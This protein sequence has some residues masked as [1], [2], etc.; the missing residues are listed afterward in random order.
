MIVASMVANMR[1]LHAVGNLDPQSGGPSRSVPALCE[2]LAVRGCRIGL[3]ARN[4]QFETDEVQSAKRRGVELTL[5]KTHSNA[6]LLFSGGR[7]L[8]RTIS[9]FD[10]VHNH[11]IWH[12]FN[13]AVVDAAHRLGK[14][15]I[16]SPR[17]MLEPWALGFHAFRKRLAWSL[18]Q[19]RDLDRV[20]AVHAT[21]PGE[22]EAIRRAGLRCP[23]AVIPN[24]TISPPPGNSSPGS[25]SIVFLSRIHPKKGLLVLIEAVGRTAS[26]LRRGG[27]RIDVYGHDEVGHL[28][29][30]QYAVAAGGLQD[31]VK[32]HHPVDGADRW[33]ILRSGAVLVLPTMSE[34]FGMVVVEALACGI[35]VITTTAAPWQQ[36]EEFRCGW[37]VPP[38][39]DGLQKALLEA[40]RLPSMELRAMGNRGK[41]LVTREYSWTGVATR[42]VEF[43]GWC[44]TGGPQPSYVDLC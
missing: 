5:A 34:N 24:G 23:V 33:A 9:G 37:W 39:V 41:A 26:E 19:R 7:D 16:I 11:G 18:F 30:I 10:I 1:T 25:R 38:D 35:P 4:R 21:S 36:L 8:E 28:K 40:T 31:L 14:M 27:W 13:H 6:R 42:M 3:L 2:A 20:A 17:G 12:P 44:L 43:Y 32:L 22:L 29:Q 15:I